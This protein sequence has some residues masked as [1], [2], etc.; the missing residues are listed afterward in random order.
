MRITGDYLK[1]GVATPYWVELRDAGALSGADEDAFKSVYDSVL[2]GLA[3]DLDEDMEVA[4][5]GVSMTRK[6][7]QVKVSL[8]MVNQQR[9][10]LLTRL[11]T[12]WSFTD[13]PL[14]YTALSRER[15]P[16][17]V[18]K[19]LDAATAEHKQVLNAS[20]PD[21]KGATTSASSNG[22]RAA[23]QPRRKG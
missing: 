8:G 4:E 5:D 20:G 22:S 3:V 17:P 15:L 14:P 12:D 9:D 13:I 7:R 23:S 10:V 2:G 6:P 19:A 21:P 1:D 18:C 16:L 11:I